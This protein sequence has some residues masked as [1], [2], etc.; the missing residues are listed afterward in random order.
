MPTPLTAPA[1]TKALRDMGGVSMPGIVLSLILLSLGG[2][3]HPHAK[4]PL[5]TVNPNTQAQLEERHRDSGMRLVHQAGRDVLTAATVLPK[6]AADTTPGKRTALTTITVLYPPHSTSPSQHLLAG[7]E[8]YPGQTADFSFMHRMNIKQPGAATGFS[9]ENGPD[10]YAQEV[11]GEISN[12]KWTGI[13]AGTELV[14]DN[15]QKGTLLSSLAGLELNFTVSNR[16]DSSFSIH[17][18]LLL[19]SAYGQEVSRFLLLSIEPPQGDV[20]S[21]GTIEIFA[22]QDVVMKF[23]SRLENVTDLRSASPLY[24]E[25]PVHGWRLPVIPLPTNETLFS[26]SPL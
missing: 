10:Y 1:G 19:V 26:P 22:G 3:K 16:T 4:T 12:Q 13:A 9:P 15:G 17:P 21:V 14:L 18:P 11:V 24:L 8:Y 7:H 25:F 2:W 20:D 5:T 6:D 23:Q